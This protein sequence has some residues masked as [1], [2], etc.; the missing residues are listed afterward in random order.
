VREITLRLRRL[1]ERIAPEQDLTAWPSAP[2]KP[3]A[4]SSTNCRRPDRSGAPGYYR[5]LRHCG[6]G[7]SE[8]SRHPGGRDANS[9]R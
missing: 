1:E 3:R 7:V 8:T 4:R 2:R 5:L 9:Y 6:S